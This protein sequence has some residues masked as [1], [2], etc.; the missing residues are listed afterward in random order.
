MKKRVQKFEELFVWQEARK[1]NRELFFAVKDCKQY[2][3]KDQ[4]LRASLSVSSN[5]AE[6]FER[7]TNKEFIRFL[8]I[9]RASCGEVRSQ[10]YLAMDTHLLSQDKAKDLI[11]HSKRISYL[12]FK[13]IK[14]IPQNP[15]TQ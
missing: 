2:F 11:S 7:Q 6:G 13:L 4:I 10:L 12:L 14:S 15:P 8:Y 1:L 5:I 9:A 3:F